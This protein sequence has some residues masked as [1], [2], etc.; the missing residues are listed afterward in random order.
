MTSLLYREALRSEQGVSLAGA[1]TNCADLDAE[2]RVLEVD[3][4]DYTL[5]IDVDGRVCAMDITVG[6][7]G[8]A[9]VID[10]ANL[11]CDG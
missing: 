4:G 2:Q 1:T 7:R 8:A 3:P 10:L 9:H 11:P 5:D 6:L